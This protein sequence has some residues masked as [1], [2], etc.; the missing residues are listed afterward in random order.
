MSPE[1]RELVEG[2]TPGFLTWQDYSWRTCC[3]RACVYLGQAKAEDIAPGGKWHGAMESVRAYCFEYSDEEWNFILSGVPV[4]AVG[5]YVF[6]CRVCG[7]LV[8]FWDCH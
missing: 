5:I 1:D 2:R 3:G 6:E 4:G 8:G 7:G